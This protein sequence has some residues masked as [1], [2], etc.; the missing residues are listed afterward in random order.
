MDTT[1]AYP[2][3]RWPIDI[4]LHSAGDDHILVVR[5]PLGIS[6]SPLLLVPAVA[7]IL[8]KFDGGSSFQQIL[9]HFSPEGLDETTLKEL[10]RLLDE[11]RFLANAR[12]FAADKE[13]REV[14]AASPVRLP[15]MAGLGYPNTGP[16]LRQLVN[17]YLV[18]YQPST[19]QRDLVALVS[20]HIDYRR[21]GSCYGQIYPRLIESRA[22]LYVLIGT[23][24]QYSRNLFHLC[25][26]DFE[27]P[28]ATL[29]CDTQFVTQLAHRYGLARAFQDE[30]LHKREHSLELQLPFL[31]ALVPGATIVPVLV[32]GFH[33]MLAR[34]RYPHEY[35]E[36]ETFSAALAELIR[37]RVAGGSRVCFV[38]GVDMAHIGRSFGDEG[39][40]SQEKMAEI[41]RRDAE[42][43]AAI[44]ARDKKRLFDHMAEDCDAR[45]MCGFPTLY[46]VLD[47]MDRIGWQT[48]CCTV[49]YEQAVD[50]VT[51][52]AVTFAGM[53]MYRVVT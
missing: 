13:I 17:D 14:F 46:T 43:L 8:S 52:C 35:E 26:K 39:A 42:Y 47:V 50:Y 37:E 3:L 19:S 34:N 6:D 11:H 32:G 48:E 2:K 23:A 29:A 40:L 51:D 31:S 53:A 25:A 15:A 10:I 49:K 1:Y 7:P 44:E 21:G 45:R 27:C 38:A 36:Y 20:P 16:A 33:S 18:P 5:C 28:I 4:N 22:D 24:H 30:F 12:F 9:D 41:A